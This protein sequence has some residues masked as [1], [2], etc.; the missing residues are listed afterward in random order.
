[1]GAGLQPELRER[2]NFH[3]WHWIR[4]EAFDSSWITLSLFRRRMATNFCN[5]ALCSTEARAAWNLRK[6]QSSH[7]SARI[8][9]LK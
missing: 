6:S 4:A 2:G 8:E 1:M 9:I 7:Q 5:K 3:R